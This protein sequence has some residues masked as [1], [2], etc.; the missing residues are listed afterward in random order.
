MIA[1]QPVPLSP[2]QPDPCKPVAVNRDGLHTQ[3]A[4]R[5]ETKRIGR[6]LDA[7]RAQGSDHIFVNGAKMFRVSFRHH[8]VKD[9]AYGCGQY[10]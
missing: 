10:T 8:G 5:R 7:N 3:Q 4:G 1:R 6:V 9:K 2:V